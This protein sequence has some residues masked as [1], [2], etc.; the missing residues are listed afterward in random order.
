MF[1]FDFF[2]HIPFINYY[3]KYIFTI[4]IPSPVSKLLFYFIYFRYNLASN[5]PRADVEELR[6]E[7]LVM[8]KQT[9]GR[10][11]RATKRTYQKPYPLTY[12][13][14]QFPQ[15][16]RNLEFTKFTGNDDRTTQ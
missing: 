9:F 10:D 14:V 5:Q 2:C 6:G 13:C 16:F 12:E 15:G 4:S 1:L 3:K 11:P 7:M 8:F